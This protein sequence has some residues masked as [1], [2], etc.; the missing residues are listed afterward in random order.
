MIVHV[1]CLFD[2]REPDVVKYVGVTRGRIRLRLLGHIK[3]SF[4]KESHLHKSRWIRKIISS[5][6]Y[7]EIRLLCDVEEYSWQDAERSFIALYKGTL[8]NLTAGGNGL[9]V[10]G[11]DVSKKM[12]DYQKARFSIS[13]EREKRSIAVKNSPLAI[14]QR[15]QLFQS[16]RGKKKT[17]EHI[18]NLVASM[19]SSEKCA[20]SIE[21][22]A[23]LH[24]GTKASD[25]TKM[26]MSITRKG[27]PKSPE[28]R[29]KIKASNLL[30]RARQRG[31]VA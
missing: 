26:K 25:E 9:W 5:G 28:H 12:S 11:S 3:G 23:A 4:G 29:A 31:D 27:V 15:E 8:T 16:L 21:R 14:R 7:P 10:A 17:P 1:Y 6:T 22:L 13:G 24:L 18:K 30:T 19:R 2:P 20:K